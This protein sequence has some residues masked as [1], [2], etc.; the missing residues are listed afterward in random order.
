MAHHVAKIT[1]LRHPGAAIPSELLLTVQELGKTVKAVADKCS[2][3]I[4]N[5]DLEKAL[6]MEKDDDEVDRLHRKLFEALLDESWPHSTE[7]AI[8]M[9]LIGRY[10]ERYADHA[11]SIARRV[12]FL[13]TGTYS[14]KLV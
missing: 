8:D 1:R 7:T 3:V 9:T 11:V 13:V 5:R 4:A 12:Y 6:E 10:Y 2:E 14:E